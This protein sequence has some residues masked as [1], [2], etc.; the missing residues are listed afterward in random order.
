MKCGGCG[1]DHSEYLLFEGQCSDCYQEKEKE[2]TLPE[3]LAL[4]YFVSVLLV[5]IWL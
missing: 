1:T 2:F 5:I 4:L 3:L